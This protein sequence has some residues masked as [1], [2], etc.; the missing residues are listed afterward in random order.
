MTRTLAGFT[1]LALMLAAPSGYAEEE[2]EPTDAD[3][4]PMTVEEILKRDPS[5]D[6][7]SQA[8]RCVRTD[9]IRSIDVLDDKHI[10]FEVRRNQYYLV[11]FERR[12]L[13]LRRNSAVVFEPTGNR[14]CKLDG[15]RPIDDWGGVPGAKCTINGFESVTKEQLVMLKETLQAERRKKRDA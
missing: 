1:L 6:D 3:E 5:D 11:Q 14:L 2:M 9:Q 7:Y 15:I 10:A 4:P 12:C 8:E 13:G